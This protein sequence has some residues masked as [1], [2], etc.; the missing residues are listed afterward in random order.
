MLRSDGLAMFK[1]VKQVCTVA[2]LS[3][4]T[5]TNVMESGNIVSRQC[6]LY[7]IVL[8]EKLIGC[9]N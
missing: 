6:A 7:I 8:T 5:S 1:S 9:V 3:E 2:S 4:A